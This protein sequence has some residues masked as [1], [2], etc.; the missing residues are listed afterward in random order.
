MSADRDSRARIADEQEQLLAAL[1]DGAEPPTGFDTERLAAT[2]RAL[3]DKK[4]RVEQ[5]RRVCPPTPAWRDHM[6]RWLRRRS[7]T[8]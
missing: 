5:K 6:K 1:L 7:V 3:V 2:S 4:R 8:D